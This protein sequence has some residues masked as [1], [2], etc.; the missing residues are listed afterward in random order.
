MKYTI[1][2]NHSTALAP[3]AVVAVAL[4]D[5]RPCE[6]TQGRWA[7]KVRPG[8]TVSKWFMSVC[9][10]CLYIYIYVHIYIY[11]Y[12]FFFDIS[13]T[14]KCT[15]NI[16]IYICIYTYLYTMYIHTYGNKGTNMVS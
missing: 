5:R 7:P 3:A 16:Y 1:A 12:V 4:R 10:P 13:E 11:I 15:I 14:K 8:T 9:E 6:V 2:S